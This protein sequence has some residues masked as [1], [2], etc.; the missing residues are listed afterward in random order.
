MNNRRRTLRGP[1]LSEPQHGRTPQW[2]TF[3]GPNLIP[4]Q[5][6]RTP[7]C[8]RTLRGPITNHWSMFLLAISFL[9]SSLVGQAPQP[10]PDTP[11]T[12]ENELN[13][14][15]ESMSNI[16]RSD[17][18]YRLGGGDL[19]EV[20]VYGVDK[21]KHELR[22]NSSGYIH[23]PLVGDIEVAGK[24][25]SEVE[26]ELKLRLHPDIIKDPH[27]S[28]FIKDYRSQPVFVLGAVRSPGQYQITRQIQLV[29]IIAMAGG[30]LPKAADQLTLQRRAS[31]SEPAS[32]GAANNPPEITQVDLKELLVEGNL[33]LNVPI[34]GG[35]VINVPEKEVKL[36]YVIGQVNRPG[37]FALPEGEKQFLLTQAI[38]WAGGPGKT[39]KL[40]KG[41]LVRYEEVS[42]AR[43]EIALDFKKVLNGK[44]PDVPVQPEDVIFIPG[45][46]AKTIGYAMLNAVPTLAQNAIIYGPR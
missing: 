37:A 9:T 14:N 45:S 33:A 29:D 15:L 44:R 46:A 12:A 6:G 18:E 22:I 4:P 35:D 31:K 1:N 39:A 21:F 40:S 36:F 24:T 11:E 25:A 16:Y 32:E 19:I 7:Q 38:A 42:G 5:H 17:G 13:K 43:Q 28:V 20:S 2:R 30:L 10:V 8:R 23:L 26:R 3:R 34:R 41:I 27:V